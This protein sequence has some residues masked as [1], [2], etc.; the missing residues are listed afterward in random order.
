MKARGLVDLLIPRGGAGLIR[1]VVE[2]STVPVIETGVGNCHVFVDATADLARAVEITL[3]AKVQRPSVCNSAETL[4]VHA[5]VAAD[6]LPSVLPALAGRGRAAARRR[7]HGRRRVV[8]RRAGRAGD[9]RGLGD[10]VPGARPGRAGGRLARRGDRAHPA[11]VQ[12]A[13]RGDPAPATCG[14]PTGSRPRSTAP[15]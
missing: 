6:F 3:N 8:V 12:R 14:R 11:L 10:R 1:T 4:L 13:H 7:A 5:A 2:N 15:P 9:R